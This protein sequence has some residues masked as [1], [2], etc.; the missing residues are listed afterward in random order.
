MLHHDIDKS[1]AQLIDLGLQ[2]LLLFTSLKLS[3]LLPPGADTGEAQEKIR[4]AL[5]ASL[6]EAGELLIEKDDA[7]FRCRKPRC[8]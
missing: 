4:G 6:E 3:L 8:P 7:V 5:A 2:E 1:P